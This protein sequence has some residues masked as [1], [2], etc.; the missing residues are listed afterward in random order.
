MPEAFDAP[1]QTALRQLARWAATETI[2]ED[3]DLVQS[4][5]SGDAE[6]WGTLVTR[7]T[8]R[9][10]VHLD[11]SVSSERVR[12]TLEF[13][14]RYELHRAADIRAETAAS[15]LR[16]RLRAAV[17]FVGRATRKEQGAESARLDCRRCGT[18]ARET[19]KFCVQCGVQL[20]PER[21]SVQAEGEA[22]EEHFPLVIQDVQPSV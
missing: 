3:Q 12:E 14:L 9:C 8:L 11:S 16:G 18:R 10:I 6:A 20:Q 4:W 1:D 13:A 7:T 2:T 5:R 19:A 17:P 22:T 15:S 21:D